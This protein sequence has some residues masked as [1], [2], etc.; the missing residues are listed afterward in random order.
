MLEQQETINRY[1]NYIE[2]LR[3]LLDKIS[4]MSKLVYGDKFKEIYQIIR[5]EYS[6]KA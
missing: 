5:D 6:L 3:T 4:T 1:K 2:N